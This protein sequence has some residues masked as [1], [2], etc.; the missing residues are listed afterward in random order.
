MTTK[1]RPLGDRILIERLEEAVQ[2]SPGGIIIPDTAKEKPTQGK[3]VAVGPGRRAE[4]GS[5]IK[6]DVQEGDRVL[7]GKWGGTDVKIDGKEYVI[8]KEEDVYG[9][10]N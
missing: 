10:V 3:V 6:P 9:V 8:L 7:F 1:I 5:L 2:K 4:D